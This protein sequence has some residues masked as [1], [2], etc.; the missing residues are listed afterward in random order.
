MTNDRAKKMAC[1]A[2]LRASLAADHGARSNALRPGPSPSI[3]YSIFRKTISIRTVCG[4][5]QPHQSRPKAAVNTAIPVRNSKSPRANTRL[6]WGQK[7][8]PRTENFRSMTLTMSNGLPLIFTNEPP[9]HHGQQEPREPG[10]RPVVAAPG[11]LRVKPLAAALLVGRG[12]VVSK[13]RPV[14][15]PIHTRSGRFWPGPGFPAA[16][17]A[18]DGCRAGCR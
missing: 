9:E 6:S 12:Q 18:G 8:T 4:Q 1:L 7:M 13:V 2:P 15:G 3:R 11:L 16:W 10:A 5:V 17:D 14:H